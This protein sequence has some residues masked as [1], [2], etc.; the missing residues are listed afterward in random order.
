M[1]TIGNMVC[2]HQP[3]YEQ[4][5]I[6]LLKG[7]LFGRDRT[8]WFSTQLL[9]SEVC[10]YLRVDSNLT[11]QEDIYRN[12]KLFKA[13]GYIAT[14]DDPEIPSI[15]SAI[16]KRIHRTKKKII[17]S[18]LSEAQLRRFEPLMLSHIDIFI[19]H[20]LDASQTGEIVDMTSRCKYVGLDISSHFGFGIPLNLQTDEK[21]RFLVKGMQAAAYRTYVYMQYLTAK[22]LG[23]ELLLIRPLYAIRKLYRE[24]LHSLVARRMEM[25]IHAQDDLISFVVDTKDPETGTVMTEKEVF[26][27]AE[28]F[29]IAGMVYSVLFYGPFPLQSVDRS[30]FS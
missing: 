24:A 4:R 2:E 12:D 18:G 3:H 14:Q 9:H 16:D 10:F 1:K 20:L 26:A 28:V 7:P 11:D 6:H 8:N 29:L 25:E 23:V 15:F 17:S 21:N 13:R 22:Y 27:E 30:N 5:L 19:R